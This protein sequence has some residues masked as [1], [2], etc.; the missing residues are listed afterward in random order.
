[1]RTK[2]VLV[3][4]ILLLSGS[5]DCRPQKTESSQPQTTKTNAEEW[6]S[7]Q[8]SSTPKTIREDSSGQLNDTRDLK[9]L[10]YIDQSL[11]TVATQLLNVSSPEETG[12][13]PNSQKLSEKNDVSP[14]NETIVNNGQPQSA[15]F[16]R[17]INSKFGYFETSHP[18][19][20]MAITEEELEREMSSTRLMTAYKNHP[21]TTG[22]ISTWILLNPPSTTMKTTETNKKTKQPLESEARVTVKPTTLMER[23][24]TTERVIERVTVPISTTITLEEP[25]GTRKTVTATTKKTTDS[26]PERTQ[27]IDKMEPLRNTSSKIAEITANNFESK[28]VSV[29]PTKKVYTVRTT[30]KP[31]TATMKTTVLSKPSISKTSR[32][33]Q[34]PRPKPLIRRT[35]V[36]SDIAKNE[37][38]STA[39]VEK[40]TFRPVQ[41]I[42]IPKSKPETTEKPMFVTKIKASILMET[43]KTTVPSVYSTINLTTTSK[44][45]TPDGDSIEMPAK[46]K[47]I[48]TKNNVLK[49]HLKKPLDDTK[50]EIQPIKVN[51][52]ILKIEKVENVD[53]KEDDSLNN[54]R[55]DLKFDFNPELTKI[56][57]DTETL[58]SSTTPTSTSTTKR[59]RQ[60][61]KRK[62]NKSR[63]RKPSTSTS[64]SSSSY[65]TTTTVLPLM[66]NRTEI[67]L[68]AEETVAENG[69]QE[70]K[71]VPET[72]VAVNSTKTKKKPAEKPIST[73]IY[74]FLSREVMPSFGMM[75][76]VGLGLGLASYFLYPFG[77]T[78]ARRNY[79]IEPKYKYNLDEYG[80]NYGQS[81]EEVLSKVLQGMTT[82]E[83]KYP[84]IK[85]YDNN[86]YRYQHYDGGYD[87]Q[88]TK[89]YEERYTTSSPI[90]RP[91]NTA[92]VLKYRN[93]DYRYSDSSSTSNYYERT[94]N[95]EYVAGQSVPDSANRQFVVGNVPKQYPPY[96]EK[97]PSLSTSEKFVNGYE[98]T[99]SD[100]PQ[101]FNFPG[102]S[103]QG[104]GQI[105]TARPEDGY[106]EVEITPTAVAVEHGPRSLKLERFSPD[107][108]DSSSSESGPVRS[109]KKRDSVIQI[110]PT[111]RELEEEE[112]EEDLSNE[113]LN[114]IDSALPGEKMDNKNKIQ[115]NEVEDFEAQRRRK[116]EEEKT[117]L[118]EST[119]K[120]PTTETSTAASVETS[121]Q[122]SIS[123]VTKQV[124]NSPMEVDSDDTPVQ[125]STSTEQ[126]NVE[127]IDLTTVQ[128]SEQPPEQDGFNIFNVVKKIAEIKFRLG[129]TLL[130]HASEGF[131]RYLGHVQKRINGEE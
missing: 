82:D 10:Q 115:D 125:S 67:E 59:L 3:V 40:V 62:K 46:T 127:W 110:I 6:K 66:T 43:Q 78:I 56:N 128:P 8:P 90:Y 36:K 60:S 80:G 34:Q 32:P 12:N 93:T 89:K 99:E 33:T 102:S 28:E 77:G 1:M 91:E 42:T 51:A 48:V 122:E 71:I 50:I 5:G 75:S 116:K 87:P 108:M 95:S 73:Q 111:K 98:P 19:Q 113:I 126:S 35:T 120:V 45:T 106:E 105:Q 14:A 131:A 11:R 47:P 31:K 4:V 39:K 15:S 55:I 85:D 54:S 24:E 25:I 44:P 38:N 72:K 129:L 27:S 100:Q 63:R 58:S 121:T 68:I 29:S 104:Y 61:L 123:S 81:E 130:K 21:T 26:K 41:M 22:G 96:E 112:K 79:E 7:A 118:K 16:G 65:T 117:R 69:I 94:K 88:M 20:A 84:G 17:P 37:N 23:A 101:N 119:M 74:N 9:D 109:R 2:L 30:P 103:V 86:Y 53:P 13:K 107:T 49:A 92:S 97:I 52:P 70:S 114:I 83:T 18:G 64:T 76:L 124:A 57:V